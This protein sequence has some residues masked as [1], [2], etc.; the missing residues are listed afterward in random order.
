[1]K[2]SLLFAFALLVAV[3]TTCQVGFKF[4]ADA[5]APPLLSAAWVLRVLAEPW[6]YVVIIG[7]V[8]AFLLYMTILRVAPVGPAFA[9]TH[10]EIVTVLLFSVFFLGESLTIMQTVGCLAVFAGV[11]VL[12]CT[13]T[14]G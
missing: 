3:D 12:G 14:Q 5:T 2:T 7:Y 9:V 6:V 8:F 1:V 10:L 11:I 13:E 4:V